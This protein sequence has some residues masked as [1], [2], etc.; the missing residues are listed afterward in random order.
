MVETWRSYT[1]CVE[2]PNIVDYVGVHEQHAGVVI[3]HGRWALTSA[4]ALRLT[5]PE[6]TIDLSTLE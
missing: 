6:S 3:N 5:K 2:H 4:S 1:I